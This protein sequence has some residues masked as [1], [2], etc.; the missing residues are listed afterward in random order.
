MQQ[1]QPIIAEPSIGQKNYLLSL[2]K[3]RH[4]KQVAYMFFEMELPGINEDALNKT[5][6]FFIQRHES[7]R[8]VFLLAAGSIK[9]VVLPYEKE[10]YSITHLVVDNDE[11]L[12][13]VR[14]DN[15]RQASQQFARIEEGP[16]VKTFL[17]KKPGNM[18]L[19][20]FLIHH[21]LC[22]AWSEKIVE[23]ELMTI[24]RSYV[25]GSIPSLPPLT[26]QLRNY[27]AQLNTQVL[28]NR[29]GTGAYWLNKLAGYNGLLQLEAFHNQ[30]QQRHGHT[31]RG[32]LT[33]SNR[34]ELSALLQQQGSAMYT[35]LIDTVHFIK[36][37][38]LARSS[39]CSVSAIAYAS[40]YIFFYLYPGK[41]RQ[42]FA[43]L[44][45][46]RDT[47]E[48]Q[49]VIGSLLGAIY[50]PATV[51]GEKTVAALVKETF[52]QVL[53]ASQYVIY[54]HETI[55]LDGRALWLNCD[56]YL[57][58]MTVN[59]EM[60]AAGFYRKDHTEDENIFYALNCMLIEYSDGLC[61]NW[62]Y[63]T[64]LFTKELIEDMARCHESIVQYITG[65]P[66]CTVNEIKDHF[67][68]GVQTGS[69]L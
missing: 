48:K 4:D 22:D 59:K 31:T 17:F 11:H 3:G 8:T 28:E 46:D 37:K 49:S 27:C 10:K 5:I 56:L 58:Y 62:R 25:T 6:S 39:H 24:Y 43:I 30:Y 21:V 65:H 54:D 32:M 12:L 50:L 55:D 2:Q 14:K 66:A 47:R 16:L 1:E 53:E 40:F 20:S 34:D 7:L 36:L 9:Q 69:T 19:F 60:L 45:A 15:Y 26:V 64:G 57:N 42:L 61:I 29:Y 68:A 44:M 35:S 23:R 13:Q 63:N 18:Y 38:N 52:L 33:Y 41:T 51:S 67:F